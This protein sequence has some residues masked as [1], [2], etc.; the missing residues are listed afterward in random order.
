[1]LLDSEVE[2]AQTLKERANRYFAA[3]DLEKSLPLYSKAVKFDPANPLLVLN[4]AGECQPCLYKPDV[5]LNT[6]TT[7]ISC[8]LYAI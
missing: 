1:M 2:R 4:R 7:L 3:G 6:V 8:V 5:L